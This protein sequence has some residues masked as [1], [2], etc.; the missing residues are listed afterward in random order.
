M[1]QEILQGRAGEANPVWP[2][3]GRLIRVTHPSG[4]AVSFALPTDADIP[5]S[6]SI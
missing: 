2:H 4:G 1:S 5:E 3:V 6:F